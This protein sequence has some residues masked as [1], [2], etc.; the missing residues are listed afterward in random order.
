M[1]REIREEELKNAESER[2]TELTLST[3][4]LLVIGCGLILLC[5][6]CFGLGYSV[7]HRSSAEPPATVSPSSTSTI[8]AQTVG[9][10]SKP[11]AAGQAPVQPRNQTAV[12]VPVESGGDEAHA[13]AVAPVAANESSTSA[14][15]Q[16]KP[17]LQSQVRP[18]LSSQMSGTPASLPIKVQPALSQPPGLMVQ[19]AAVS[20]TEDAEVL[21][22]ALRRRGYA[23]AVRREVADSLLHVQIGPFANRNDANVMRQKLLNDGYNAIVQQ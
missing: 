6:I 3:G 9:S 15:P 19:I 20:R 22:N 5:G 21:V 18:A 23:V 2:D 11:M 1:I 12:N 10:T 13:T 8:S 14:Q 7:G 4:M 16:V 17:A